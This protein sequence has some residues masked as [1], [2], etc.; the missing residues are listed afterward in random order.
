MGTNRKRPCGSPAFFVGWGNERLG[1]VTRDEKEQG[2]LVFLASS[3]RQSADTLSAR[4]GTRA[5]SL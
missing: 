1:C 2:E 5:A 4:T 3:S